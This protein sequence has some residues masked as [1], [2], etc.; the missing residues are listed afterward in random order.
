MTNF[1]LYELVVLLL[2]EMKPAYEYNHLPYEEYLTLGQNQMREVDNV[3]F[4][5]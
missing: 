4:F 2:E 1:E 3:I 5:N